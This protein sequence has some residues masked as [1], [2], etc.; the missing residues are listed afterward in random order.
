MSAKSQYLLGF[1]EPDHKEQANL[2]AAQAAIMWKE[3]EKNEVGK[4]L[5][6]PAVA[7]LNWLDQVFHECHDCRVD[8]I[9]I[10]VYDWNCN[11]HHAMKNLLHA[12]DRFHKPIWLTEFACPR[13]TSA[14]E[15]LRYMKEILPLLEGA[16]Y[17]FLYAGFAS[18]WMVAG[19]FVDQSASLLKPYSTELTPLGHYY[20]FIH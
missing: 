5:V 10:H 7:N 6:S 11:A 20:N 12:L 2:T 17:L 14:N 16:L 15:Q 18:R 1:N 4:V 9:S 8:H 13:T 3:V 19:N